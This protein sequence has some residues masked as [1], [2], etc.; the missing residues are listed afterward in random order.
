MS[1]NY[2]RITMWI[3]DQTKPFCKQSIQE[4]S[5]AR[6]ETVDIEIV[7]ISKNGDRKNIQPI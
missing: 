4:S 7:M 3:I 6:N 2:W 5:C 1:V